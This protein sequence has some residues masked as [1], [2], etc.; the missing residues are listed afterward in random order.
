MAKTREVLVRVV[1]DA[2]EN[3]RLW[4]I[5]HDARPT[6]GEGCPCPRAVCTLARLALINLGEETA[7]EQLQRVCR[8][9]QPDEK[10]P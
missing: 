7:L 4:D 5:A 1:E 3:L 9:V 2:Q 10:T 6:H 8:L